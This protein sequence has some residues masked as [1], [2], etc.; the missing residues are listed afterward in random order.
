MAENAQASINLP[1]QMETK[2]LLNGKPFFRIHW[3][4]YGAEFYNKEL[5]FG[6]SNGVLY[7]AEEA[8]GAVVEV[9]GN[10]ILSDLKAVA[11]DDLKNRRLAQFIIAEPV[12]VVS[13][14]G[15]DLMKNGVDA[16]I[17]SGNHMVAQQWSQSILDHP[18]S[19]A[20]I[21]YPCRHHAQTHSVALF[22]G[23]V[24]FE[25]RDLGPLDERPDVMDILKEYDVD[26]LT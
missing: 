8:L 24:T 1:E 7:A 12:E 15:T 9:F 19:Y 14:T 10:T 21:Y 4:E 13:F 26:I 16:T 18:E 5:R 22:Q 6:N 2:S 3:E 17:F 20:G 25:K 23:R 11:M